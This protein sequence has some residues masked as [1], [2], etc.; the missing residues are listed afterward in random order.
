MNQKILLATVMMAAA[1]GAVVEGSRADSVSAMSGLAQAPADTSCF[2]N[3]FGSITNICTG[4]RQ[5]CVSPSVNSNNR[6]VEVTVR[7]PDASHPIGCFAETVNRNGVSTGGSGIRQPAIVGSSQVV[8][9]GFMTE[10]GR[11]HV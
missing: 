6:F 4:T 5:Y 1:L 8:S 3:S 11:A 10:I 9:L 2:T 7:A